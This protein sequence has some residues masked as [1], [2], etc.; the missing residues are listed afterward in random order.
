MPT[1]IGRLRGSKRRPDWSAGAA[2]HDVDINDELMRV[3]KKFLESGRPLKDVKDHVE[4][5]P[6][7]P[8]DREHVASSEPA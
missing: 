1:V 3:A 7:D 2:G 4:G 6:A 5:V 8:A